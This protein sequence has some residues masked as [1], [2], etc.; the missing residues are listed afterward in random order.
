MIKI[1]VSPILICDSVYNITNTA[2][3]K[4]WIDGTLISFNS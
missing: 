1:R 4:K 2:T 3:Y